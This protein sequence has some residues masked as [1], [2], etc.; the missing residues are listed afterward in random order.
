MSERGRLSTDLMDEIAVLRARVAELEHAEA[1]RPDTEQALRESRARLRTVVS[2][3]P[4]ILFSLDAKGDVTLSEGKALEALG[5]KPGQ[6]VGKSV[7]ELYQDQPDILKAV[8]RGLAGETFTDH[9]QVGEAWLETRFT[10]MID[11]SGH[12]IGC[13]GVATDVSD[14]VRAER[15]LRDSEQ[16]F[17]LLAE[18]IPGLIY[19]CHNDAPYTMVYMNDMAEALT[20]YAPAEFLDNCI[21]FAQLMHPD[22]L[23]IVYREVEA[24]IAQRRAFH[25]TYRLRHRDGRLLWMEE[26]GVGVFMDDKLQFLEGY[27]IDIT[28][29]VRDH[30]AVKQA[31]DELEQRVIERTD[32]LRAS[33]ERFRQLAE[34]IDQV[35]WLTDLE[36]PR[37]VYVSPAYERI[38]GKPAQGLYDQPQDWIDSIH[39]QDRDRVRD[40]WQRELMTGELHEEYR[41]VRPDGAVRWIRD[42]GYPIHDEEG[43]LIRMAGVAM[44]ITDVRDAEARARKVQEELAHVLRLYTVNEMVTGLAHELN[45]PLAAIVNFVHGTRRRIASG[46][47]D[48]GQLMSACEKVAE[49]AERASEIV[50]GIRRF[51]VSRESNS[52]PSDLNRVV[53]D[54]LDL[55]ASDREA[56][57]V[58]THLE[59]TDPLPSVDID[60]VQIQQVI[61]NLVRNAVEAMSEVEESHRQ[62]EIRTELTDKGLV[63]V[64]V[65]DS[66]P[67][68][69][70]NA[71]AHLFDP[72]FTTKHQGLG[73]GL[74]ISRSIVESHRGTLQ[75]RNRTGQ[76][77]AGASFYFTLPISKVS[78]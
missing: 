15:A 65:S 78:E 70:A 33:E 57:Q 56:A 11:S 41:I 18:N 27:I 58:T 35:F 14:R 22:D 54:A 1:T 12:V 38:W 73:M 42:R 74:S 36:P 13:I 16:K 76:G 3:A 5:F 52:V 64:T 48:Q 37:V 21:T 31:R 28:E 25:L 43:K 75:F 72:F 29:R 68:L 66:G 10:P 60:A 20:G 40:S 53:R 39:P 2:N 6:L 59:L 55:A 63:R 44:D 26:V 62:I 47:M 49:Q 17:R 61:L 24:A 46:V 8:R 23:K 34:N 51:V 7:F 45:Q 30:D 71:A 50:R 19:L 69:G 77:R 32:E 9:A 4:I 67:G